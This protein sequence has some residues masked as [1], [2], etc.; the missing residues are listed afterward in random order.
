M[1]PLVVKVPVQLPPEPRLEVLLSDAPVV[2]RP[3]G[4]VQVPDEVVQY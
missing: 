2:D 4:V 1:V 3:V